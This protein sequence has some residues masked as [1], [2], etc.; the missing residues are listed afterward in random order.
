MPGPLVRIQARLPVKYGALAQLYGLMLSSV[1]GMLTG[2]G[3]RYA[4]RSIVFTI[5]PVAYWW[6]AGPSNRITEFDSRQGYHTAGM[7]GS[8]GRSHKPA[9]P[10]STPG[11]ASDST[12]SN[13]VIAQLA[14]HLPVERKVTGSRPVGSAKKLKEG[15]YGFGN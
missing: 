5:G 6:G 15:D 8:L 1:T 10:G 7:G 9:S 2:L 13:G 14:E 12:K 4:S 11:P 3:V